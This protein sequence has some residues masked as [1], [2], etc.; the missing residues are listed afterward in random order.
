M[1]GYGREARMIARPD[2][3]LPLPLGEVPRRGGEGNCE[4][5]IA[6]CEVI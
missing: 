2:M 1:T 4:L 6:H 3:I 5:R